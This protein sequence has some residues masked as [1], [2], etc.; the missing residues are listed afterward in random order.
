MP[1]TCKHF[2]PSA[3]TQ[4]HKGFEPNPAYTYAN[5]ISKDVCCHPQ[6]QNP[7]TI[8]SCIFSYTMTMSSCNLYEP[9]PSKVLKKA[10]NGEGEILLIIE[11]KT[12]LNQTTYLVTRQA[13]VVSRHYAHA[14]SS[15]LDSAL[16]VFSSLLHGDE[17][18]QLQ[19][20]PTE[21]QAQQNVYFA[22]VL[23]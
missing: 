15:A 3:E 6:M 21:S 18:H 1:E 22:K 8:P 7:E 23:K 5:S 12:D 13:E 17:Q 10:I 2:H 9:A 20:V 14:D 11:T 19:E 4:E 16:A